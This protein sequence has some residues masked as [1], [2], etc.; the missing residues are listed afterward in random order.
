M[1][2]IL[3]LNKKLLADLRDIAKELNI[4]R[5]ESYK[6]QDLIYQILDQQAIVAAEN[7]S[8]KRAENPDAESRKRSGSSDFNKRR[9]VRPGK[10]EPGPVFSTRG[11]ARE[12]SPNDPVKVDKSTDIEVAKAPT[13]DKDQKKTTLPSLSPSPSSKEDHVNKAEQPQAPDNRR[14]K[15]HR[16]PGPP[17]DQREKR[18]SG[19]LSESREPNE[20]TAVRQQRE[21][22]EQ[23]EPREQQEPR[24]QKESRD[25]REPRENGESKKQEQSYDFDNSIVN[26]GVLEIMPDGYGFLRSSDYH[27]LNSPD[28]IYVSEDQLHDYRLKRGDIIKCSWRRAV[29]NE[30]FRA[31]VDILGVNASAPQTRKQ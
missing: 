23:R 4:K 12:G 5:V 26:S 17:R 25:Q 18:E 9:R 29:G 1:Y 8:K 7:K 6:K 11:E 28:D 10:R 15:E 20:Q 21:P 3:E 19:E 2:D 13:P 31:A 14:K 30:R 22:K 27:Y 16:T 24:E